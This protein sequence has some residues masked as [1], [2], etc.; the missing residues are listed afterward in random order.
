M[1]SC[2]FCEVGV[3]TYT[4]PDLQNRP[5]SPFQRNHLFMGRHPYAGRFSGRREMPIERAISECRF[6]FRHLAQKAQMSSP[7]NSL[8]LAEIPSQ[9]EGAEVSVVIG[10]DRA[11][12]SRASILHAYGGAGGI[13]EGA[14]NCSAKSLRIAVDGQRTRKKD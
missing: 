4:Q 2:T 14:Q 6:S 1:I 5:F 8:T 3:P 7:P 13:G 11:Q 9:L 10:G 12:Q